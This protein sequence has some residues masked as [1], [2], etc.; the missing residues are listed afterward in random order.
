MIIN[1]K[2]QDLFVKSKH[3]GRL[4]KVKSISITNNKITEVLIYNLGSYEWWETKR[5]Y[6]IFK[7][8]CNCCCCNCKG[9][10]DG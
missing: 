10:I 1:V 9:D 8:T 7:N 6:P 4:Y 2:N 3:T 5:F